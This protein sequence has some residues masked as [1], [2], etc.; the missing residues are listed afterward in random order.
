MSP[1]LQFGHHY[2]RLKSGCLAVV[3]YV[4]QT[5][6]LIVTSQGLM[7]LQHRQENKTFYQTFGE[8]LLHVQGELFLKIAEIKLR[9]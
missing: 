1:R 9:T 7:A 4:G 6:S 3:G 8:P 5:L 2:I